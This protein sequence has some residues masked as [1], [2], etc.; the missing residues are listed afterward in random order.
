MRPHKVDSYLDLLEKTPEY[1]SLFSSARQL[2]EAQSTFLK[3]IPEQLTQYCRLGRISDGKLT[4]LVENGAVAS[5]LKQISPS[6]L[7]KLQQRGWEVTSFQI[8]VQ[9]HNSAKNPRP[10]KK[11]GHS[12]KKLKLSST[13]KTC[14]AQLAATMPDSELKNTIQLFVNQHQNDSTDPNSSEQ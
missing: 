6:L 4:V 9:A 10:F 5:K 3:F 13:A 1:A 11:Q 14:L 8:L 2:H 7:L 12:N